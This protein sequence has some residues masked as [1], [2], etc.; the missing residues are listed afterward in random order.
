MFSSVFLAEARTKLARIAGHSPLA[1]AFGAL[2]W[3]SLDRLAGGAEQGTAETQE[4]AMAVDLR[5]MS[6]P[7]DLHPMPQGRVQGSGARRAALRGGLQVQSL[8]LAVE[9]LGGQAEARGPAGQGG[10]H[11]A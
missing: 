9:S 4:A 5:A 3:C 6:I 7:I 2:E 1:R 10:A 11:A 8:Q